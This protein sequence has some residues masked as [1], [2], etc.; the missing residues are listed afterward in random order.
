MMI[1]EEEVNDAV[2]CE[3]VAYIGHHPFHVP[4]CTADLLYEACHRRKNSSNGLDDIDLAELASLPVAAWEM[5][6]IMIHEIEA[7]APWPTQLLQV[8]LSPIPKEKRACSS[9]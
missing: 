3:A 2:V 8:K 9:C 6:S 4:P 5:L 1:T 7:G